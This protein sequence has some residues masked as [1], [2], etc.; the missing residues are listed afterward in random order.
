MALEA[1]FPLSVE[2]L[3][4]LRDHVLMGRLGAVLTAALPDQ[5]S[6]WSITADLGEFAKMYEQSILCLNQLT[7]HQRSKLKELDTLT[8]SLLSAPA[9][10]GKTFLAIHRVKSLMQEDPEATVLYV[11]VHKAL[12]CWSIRRLIT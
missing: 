12:S 3:H 2:L 9:G 8:D 7:P 6:G 10:A 4:R 5:F 1:T 11:G